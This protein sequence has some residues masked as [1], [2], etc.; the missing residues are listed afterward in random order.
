ME[1]LYDL[2]AD[3]EETHN[4]ISEEQYKP[5][6]IELRASLLQWMQDT[7]DPLLQGPVPSPYFARQLKAF[8]E[9][10]ANPQ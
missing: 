5:V 7:Q 8:S 1:K 3:P 4:H 2:Q 10:T 6:L 9:R